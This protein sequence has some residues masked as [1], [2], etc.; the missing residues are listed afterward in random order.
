MDDDLIWVCSLCK[1]SFSNEEASEDGSFCHQRIK[2]GVQ[3][4]CKC[5]GELAPQIAGDGEKQG[6]LKHAS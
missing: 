5:G 3:H 1:R 4:I 2:D 6:R